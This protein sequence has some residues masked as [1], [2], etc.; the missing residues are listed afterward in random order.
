MSV[1]IDASIDVLGVA[2]AIAGAVNDNSDRG[3]F[4]DNLVETAYFNLGQHYNVLTVNLSQHPQTGG[5]NDIV[6][7]GSASYKDGTIFG[8]YGFKSGE[9]THEGDGGYI[10][11]AFQGSFTRDG[12]G[13]SHVVFNA[14]S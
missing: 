12:D 8:I 7:Y 9:F 5:L 3:A 13:G 2:Q 14:L 10:N 4:T 11:W 6:F 1:G